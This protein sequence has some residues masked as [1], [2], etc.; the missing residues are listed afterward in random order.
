VDQT[1]PKLA[2][3]CFGTSDSLIEELDTMKACSL[4]GCDKRCS[5]CVACADRCTH[6]S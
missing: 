4:A 6:D 3:R 5:G 1:L 2:F